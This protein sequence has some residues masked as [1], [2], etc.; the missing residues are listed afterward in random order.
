[1]SRSTSRAGI[2]F[3][4]ALPRVRA[5][6]ALL[7]IV[8]S[9]A[10]ESSTELAVEDVILPPPALD[11]APSTTGALQTA[12][13]AGGCFWGVEAVFEHVRGVTRAVSGY[14]GG[15]AETATYEAVTSGLTG[16]AESVEVTFDPRVVSYGKLLQVFFSV[17]HDPTQINA[18]TPDIGPQYRSNLFTVNGEQ[19][20]VARAYIA[21]LDAAGLFRARIATRVDT[22][23]AFF[24][25]EGEHQDYLPSHVHELYVIR[26]DLPKLERLRRIFPELYRETH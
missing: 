26:Y 11:V 16:H 14:A 3:A 19:E 8:A 1:V 21:Q 7:C 4:A 13:F 25:A 10:C 2:R 18:Q 9:A 15:T 20:S 5:A 17:A 22:L 23:E 12:V 6:A 24:V